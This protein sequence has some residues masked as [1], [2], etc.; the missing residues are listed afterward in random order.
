M[1]LQSPTAAS[2]MSDPSA[3]ANP[4]DEVPY[5]SKP[6]PPSHP[7][8]LAAVATLFGMQPPAVDRCRV[9]ELGCATGGNLIPMAER[10]PQSTFVGVDYS[11]VQ[12]GAA[13]R[14]ADAL[15]LSNLELRQASITD[16]GDEL[17]KFDYIISHG[18]FSWV[19]PPVQDKILELCRNLLHEHGVAYVSY[20]IFPGWHLRSIIREL[21]W[22][23][24]PPG[25]DTGERLARARSLLEFLSTALARQQS[26]YAELLKRQVDA[27]R[28]QP[29]GYL[30]HEDFET[31]N[32]PLY[33]HEFVARAA[34]GGLQYLGEAALATMF[35]S[36][37]GPAI[38]RQ[39]MRLSDDAIS[40]EQHLDVLRNRAFRQTLLCHEGIPLER[41]VTP[42]R[43]KTLYVYGW[44]RP[45]NVPPDLKTTAVEPFSDP[46]G[47]TISSPAPV[48]KAALY[49]LANQWPRAVSFDELVSA[50]ARLL[51]NGSPAVISPFEREGLGDNIV[52]GIASGLIEPTSAPDSFVSSVSSQPRVSLLSRLEARSSKVVTNRRHQSV[53]LDAVTQNIIR[54]LD[55]EHDHESLLRGL[56]ASVERGDV[57]ILVGGIPATSGEAVS[58]VLHDTLQQSLRTLAANALLVA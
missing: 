5:P 49:H 40:A 46:H 12:I 51:G 54:H 29:E 31:D 1:T 7:D 25:G 10:H 9:L 28:G 27:I 57:S 20:N 21:L 23:H 50:A 32:H 18:V 55:G 44:L 6:L 48:V 47:R 14:M 2:H 22:R 56:V 26:P 33:F 45:Q 34:A 24:A 39:V 13:R 38:E 8:R 52:Q 16:L 4:Y 53:T 43:L 19:A 3:A 42:D 17:G 36:S 35:I 15:S 30:C 58:G 41:H 37:F 11:Q